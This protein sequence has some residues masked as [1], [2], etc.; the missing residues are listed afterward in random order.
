MVSIKYTHYLRYDIEK[1][2]K[3][4]EGLHINL[5]VNVTCKCEICLKH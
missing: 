4:Q 2:K 3:K 5:D 1:Q